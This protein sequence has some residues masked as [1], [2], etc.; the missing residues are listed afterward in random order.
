MAEPKNIGRLTAGQELGF[1]EGGCRVLHQF[2]LAR[3][4]VSKAACR[5]AR[6]AQGCQAVMHVVFVAGCGLR[7]RETRAS[8]LAQVQHAAEF[9]AHAHRPGEGH[10]AHAELAFDLVHQVER[11]L[12]LAVHL[13]DEGQDGRVA[14]AA[15]LQQAR[16]CGSTPLAA[17]ITI[18]AASTAVSTR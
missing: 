4:L 8:A 14:R 3:G 7:R 12:H 1:V 10:H 5:S 11:V 18:S 2:D 17:S 15:D 9:L 13:V 6:R 16:V